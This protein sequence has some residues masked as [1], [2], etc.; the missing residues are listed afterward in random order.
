MSAASGTGL[1]ADPVRLPG[2]L[3][4]RNKVR[5]ICCLACVTAVMAFV[6]VPNLPAQDRASVEG[7]GGLALNS[8]RSHQ[9]RVGI[10]VRF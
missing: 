4:M 9:A 5:S 8:L 1:A 3:S 10:G 7:F 2:E 6:N